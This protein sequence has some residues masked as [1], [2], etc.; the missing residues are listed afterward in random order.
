LG[1][2]IEYGKEIQSIPERASEYV[3]W[4]DMNTCASYIIEK[5]GEYTVAIG[6][7]ELPN[8][9]SKDSSV[10]IQKAINALADGGKVF[11]KAGTYEVNTPIKYN[12]NLILE[13]ESSFFS[14]GTSKLGTHLKFTGV[15]D[16]ILNSPDT[17]KSFRLTIRD[18]YFEDGGINIQKPAY[19]SLENL[20]F[21]FSETKNA[22][23]KIEGTGGN[24]VSV[25]N[26]QIE[27]NYN[28]NYGISVLADHIMLDT[29]T[30]AKTNEAG[31]II[32]S[33]TVKPL[34][35]FISKLHGFRVNKYLIDV[36][37]VYNLFVSGVDD[38]LPTALDENKLGGIRNRSTNTDTH[39]IVMIWSAH[40]MANQPQYVPYVDDAGTLEIHYGQ[41]GCKSEN[42]GT[43]TISA[44]TSVTFD[45]KLARIP[46][47]V[48]CGFKTP[49]YGSWSWSATDTQIT[50]TVEVSGTYDF[51]WYAKV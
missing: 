31:I 24:F 20:A 40:T 5:D 51:S 43:E 11:V 47:H 46:T 10:V 29:I 19:N 34:D 39:N 1:R 9:K 32:G 27:G 35:I 30:I 21:N 28:I 41:P 22:A 25:S 8:Y 44:S 14:F 3:R 7:G 49:G 50:I 18:L 37:K 48:E 23:I 42:S 45:H 16:Y 4:A 26:I 15:E 12:D 6:T 2:W 33:D 17:T 13:G 38:E 36:V